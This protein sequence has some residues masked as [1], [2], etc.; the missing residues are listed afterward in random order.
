MDNKDIAEL[1]DMDRFRDP[2]SSIS[3]VESS[4]SNASTDQYMSETTPE[5]PGVKQE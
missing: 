2:I 1:V 4:F 3:P 5:S